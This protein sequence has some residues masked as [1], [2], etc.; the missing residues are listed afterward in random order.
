[1]VWIQIKI[2]KSAFFDM[3]KGWMAQLFWVKDYSTQ[4]T[5]DS[6]LWV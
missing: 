6:I 1:M 5:K 4:E 3:Q 2:K